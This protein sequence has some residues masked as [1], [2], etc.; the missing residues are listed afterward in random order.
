LLGTLIKADVTSRIVLQEWL[1]GTYPIEEWKVI[2]AREIAD[3][4]SKRAYEL[5]F[6]AVKF[7]EILKEH[8]DTCES[9]WF[10]ESISWFQ[11]S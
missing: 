2:N 10:E 9:S 5:G 8:G 7:V 3:F 11:Q 4:P 1:R 6:A